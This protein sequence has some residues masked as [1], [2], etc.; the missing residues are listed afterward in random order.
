VRWPRPLPSSSEAL[1]DPAFT[2]LLEVLGAR[3]PARHRVHQPQL[4]NHLVVHA[5]HGE[6]PRVGSGDDGAE[7]VAGATTATTVRGLR[8]R[9]AHG[10]SV[11]GIA[12]GTCS[13]G[14]RLCLR[15]RSR[16]LVL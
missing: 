9:R 12:L 10:A 3:Q 5:G 13:G 4:D 1:R 16:L 7:A 15:L 6:Q 2:K 11:R 8:V 14:A